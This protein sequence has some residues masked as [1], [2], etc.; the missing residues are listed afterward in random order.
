MAALAA[1]AVAA[2][3]SRPATA[4]AHDAPDARLVV[5]RIGAGQTV[6]PH[7]SPS[8]VVLV[9]AAGAGF[10]LGDEGER[11]VGAGDVISFEPNERHGMRAEAQELVVLAV[12]TPRPG[13]RS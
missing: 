1:A 11:A 8:S 10:V 3:S 2:N 12:I 7:V 4:I 13:A 6:T 9:V 5:F